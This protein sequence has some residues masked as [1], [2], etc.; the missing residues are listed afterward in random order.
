[1]YYQSAR[2]GSLGAQDLWVARRATPTSAFGAPMQV[3]TVNSMDSDAD[4]LL[5][6]DE[7]SLM[8]VSNRAGG[9]GDYDV[10]EATR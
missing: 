4:P 6:P 1:M 8:F 7:R 3:S 10:Y 9:L 2:A 5:S